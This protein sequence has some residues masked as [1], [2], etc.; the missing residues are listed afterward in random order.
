MADYGPQRPRR[1]GCGRGSRVTVR[2]LGLLLGVVVAPVPAPPVLLVSLSHGRVVAV[3]PTADPYCNEVSASI[4]RTYHP[5][6]SV[7]PGETGEQAAAL[8]RAVLT[9]E[10]LL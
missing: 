8:I 7:V 5:P 10:Q 1:H 4:Q 2:R 3:A 6:G 9:G